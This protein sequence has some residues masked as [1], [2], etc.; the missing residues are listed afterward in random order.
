ML[1]EDAEFKASTE[2]SLKRWK[3]K[4]IKEEKEKKEAF[5]ILAPTFFYVIYALIYNVAFTNAAEGVLYRVWIVDSGS[6]THIINHNTGF[7]RTRDSEPNE[8]V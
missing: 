8:I 4:K 3:E 5:L 6:D 2:R 1:K 7:K